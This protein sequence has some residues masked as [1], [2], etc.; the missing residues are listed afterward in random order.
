VDFAE[1]YREHR[2]EVARYLRRHVPSREVADLTSD[3]FL[4]ALTAWPRYHPDP[5]GAGPWLLTIARNVAADWARSAR[6]RYASP[7]D[8]EA[9]LRYRP[10]PDPA[11]N[12][13][14]A[15]LATEGRRELAANMACLCDSQQHAVVRH[16]RNCPVRLDCL[17]HA[18]DGRVGHGVWGGLT[19][20]QRRV[21][22]AQHP[23]VA[24]WRLALAGMG[25]RR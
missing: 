15:V 4:R 24:S 3:V 16:C 1:V 23:G 7:A 6:V 21:L 8:A 2:L 19:E 22:L 12:P 11:V 10:D 25:A 20:R 14:P 18:L 13:L 5:R 17:A 9:Q